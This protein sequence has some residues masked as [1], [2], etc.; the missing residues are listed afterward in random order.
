[1]FI[2]SYLWMTTDYGNNL[3]IG[4]YEFQVEE[5]VYWLTVARTGLSDIC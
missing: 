5:Y 2:G 1:M 3:D 4:I